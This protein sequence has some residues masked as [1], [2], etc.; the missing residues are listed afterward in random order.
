MAKPETVVSSLGLVLFVVGWRIMTLALRQ[1]AFVAPM[2]KHQEE[3]QQTVNDSGV[4][5]VV[6]HPM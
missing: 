6:R 2:V 3:R 5:G 4:Y 1:N